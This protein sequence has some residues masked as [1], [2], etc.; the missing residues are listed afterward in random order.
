MCDEGR[1][2]ANVKY[3]GGSNWHKLKNVPQ[4]C[5]TSEQT[6][7]VLKILLL[8]GAGQ[9]AV[10]IPFRPSSRLMYFFVTF[11]SFISTFLFINFRII[12]YCSRHQTMTKWGCDSGA[13]VVARL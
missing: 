7:I 6:S 1:G 10:K 8:M 3:T 9:N 4:I 12:S 11:R 2:G 13:N 5:N